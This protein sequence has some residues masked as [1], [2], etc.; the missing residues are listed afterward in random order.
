[1][2]SKPNGA[3]KAGTVTAQNYSKAQMENDSG[4][5][6]QGWILKQKPTSSLRLIPN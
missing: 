2:S 4:S 1:M 3:P 5:S 6:F